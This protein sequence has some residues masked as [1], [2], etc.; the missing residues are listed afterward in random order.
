M[1]AF[2]LSLLTW[3][4]VNHVP[5]LHVTMPRLVRISQAPDQVWLYLQPTLVTHERRDVAAVV[6]SVELELRR[7]GGP[8]PAPFFW[9]E[10]GTWDFTPG[11][12]L[13]TYRYLADPTPLVVTQ[14]RPQQPT[15]VFTAL[16]TRLDPGRWQGRLHIEREG[17]EPVL[18]TLC[19]DVTA[20]DVAV[21]TSSPGAY[22]DF[23]DDQGGGPGGCYRSVP[24]PGSTGA[25]SR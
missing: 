6:T 7:E 24:E 14:D 18:M 11:Q 25:A 12:R 20:D 13:L 3:W 9:D 21:M 8:A 10:T 22:E 15:L 17:Q 2:G 19:V 1:A 5:D 23:R 4:Q 16:D